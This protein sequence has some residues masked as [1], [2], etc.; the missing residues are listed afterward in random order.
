VKNTIL[1]DSK[2]KHVLILGKTVAGPTN[3]KKDAEGIV[4]NIPGKIPIDGDLGY[5]GLENEF[6][7]IHVPQKKPRNGT[8]TEEQKE[9]NRKFSR[10]R[11][12]V[13]HCIGRV[14]RYGCVSDIYRNRRENVDDKMMLV[15]CGLT[16]YYQRTR[17]RSRA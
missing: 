13:E 4:R 1:T 8:L 11:V 3:D 5:K 2:G 14:K 6:D 15:C 17:P 9:A 10:R 12:L 16:N 7:K